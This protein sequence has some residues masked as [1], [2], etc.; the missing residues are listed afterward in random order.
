MGDPYACPTCEKTFSEISNL[1][2]HK[3]TVCKKQSHSCSCGSSFTRKDNLKTHKQKCKAQ[4]AIDKVKAGLTA[5]A[6]HPTTIVNIT[7]N[8]TT[9]N[10]TISDGLIDHVDSDIVYDAI[11]DE[12]EIAQKS[13]ES[14]ENGTIG[15]SEKCCHIDNLADVQRLVGNALINK[16]S[17]S[18]LRDIN[19]LF[20]YLQSLIDR[21]INSNNEIVDGTRRALKPAGEA[22]FNYLK[23]H[24]DKNKLDKLDEWYHLLFHKSSLFFGP[25]LKR[26]HRK[27]YVRNRKFVE[28]ARICYL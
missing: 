27:N 5:P 19:I 13:I 23:K 18:N 16:V 17:S 3:N 1:R 22:R 9:I 2:R 12:L 28:P 25:I 14:E 26:L 21:D 15:R 4:E 11:I 24:K 6:T 8:Y 10:Q 7:N 20:N